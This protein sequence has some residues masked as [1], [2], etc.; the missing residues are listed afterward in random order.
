MNIP[1]NE[2]SI[3]FKIVVPMYNV[4]KWI[5]KCI[6]SMKIQTYT[7]FQC[8]IIDDLSTDSSASIVENDIKD[9][10]RFT[11]IIN[12]EKKY[13][14]QNIYEGIEFLKPNDEDVIVTVDG[15]DWFY[16]ENALDIVNKEYILTKCWMTYGS[17]ILYPNDSW[18]PLPSYPQEIIDKNTFRENS[19]R[20]S[21]L[22]TFK[23]KL[24]K[25]I[26]REDLLDKSG[27]FYRMGWDLAFM[28]P[29]LEMSNGRISTIKTP[30][31]VYNIEN[32]LND[33]KVD[34]NLQ[35]SV[36]AEVRQKKK[37]NPIEEK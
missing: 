36:E 8:V 30:L 11:L 19:W 35:L 16:H 6:E 4:E 14:L 18:A 32:P 3:Q 37:Y 17:Y 7:N 27:N 15:D 28:F 26:K 33:N 22:R 13:A 1:L 31:Y 29:M 24:W 9:D 23:Y 10:S 2:N 12:E 25:N 34:A 21:H 5:G 20:A